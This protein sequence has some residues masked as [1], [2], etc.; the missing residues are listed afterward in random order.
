VFFGSSWFGSVSKNCFRLVCDRWSVSWT[1]LVGG[2]LL[3]GASV[4]G[5]RWCHSAGLRGSDGKKLKPGTLSTGIFING[6]AL[7]NKGS[8][9]ETDAAEHSMQKAIPN[10]WISK[11]SAQVFEEKKIPV[12]AVEKHHNKGISE[13]LKNPVRMVRKSWFAQSPG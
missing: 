2:G 4:S 10:F 8:G 9:E 1:Y 3:S 13:D 5:W 11:D 6:G 12:W 7:A